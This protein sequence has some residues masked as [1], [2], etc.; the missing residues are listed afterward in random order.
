MVVA[1][2]GS[3]E[4]IG[5]DGTHVPYNNG[6]LNLTNVPSGRTG[7]YLS[8]TACGAPLGAISDTSWITSS[9]VNGT[10]TN[11]PDFCSTSVG[12]AT[13][14]A[15]GTGPF[16]YLWSPS[17]QTT[18]TATNLSGGTHTVVVTNAA[19]CTKTFLT[20]VA[21]NTARAAATTTRVSCP[22]GS[23]GTATASITP[24]NPNTVYDWYDLGNQT[25]ATVTGL[26]AGTYHCRVTSGSGCTD[27]V[28]VTITEVPAM[29]VTTTA[30][31]DVTCHAGSDGVATVAVA[32]GNSPYAYAWQGSSSTT[33]TATDLPVGSTVVTVTDSKGCTTQHTVTLG[34][35]DSLYV[36]Y[37]SPDVTICPGDSAIITANGS[38]GSSAY[39]YNWYS[40]GTLVGTGQT[41]TVSPAV[42]G[43][44]YKVVL[45][46]T[47][48]SPQ[49]SDSMIITFPTPLIPS[50]VPDAAQACQ[51]GAFF[52]RNT[53]NDSSEIATTYID[54]GNGSD[55]LVQGYGP[56]SSLYPEP[57]RYTVN[58]IVTSVH[59]CVYTNTLPNIVETL[60]NPTAYFTASANPATI[61]ETNI[62]MN[63]N[64]SMDVVDWKWSAPDAV[65]AQ[66]TM[67]SPVFYFPEGEIG[68]YPVTLVTTSSFGCVDTFTT[69]IHIVNDILFYA[70]NA[71][72]PDGNEYN[73]T[74]KLHIDGIDIHD[75]SLAVYNRWGQLIWET[76]DPS[77]DWDG[78]Y[79]GELVQ[80]GTYMWK[81]RVKSAYSD[82]AK[83]FNGFVS[84]LR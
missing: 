77:A 74:W 65:P 17:N 1:P 82:E 37:I 62:K 41:V 19:G 8:G 54:F 73:Q 69:I 81:A 79:N 27:T 18:A 14:T 25:T 67:E 39:I 49:A 47:C 22:G 45:T 59:G 10:I 63:N 50:L 33:A 57:N 60:K 29:T 7:Y 66:S 9:A 2:N 76:K 31:T 3:I 32:N 23:D 44:Y 38:G 71:F 58:M 55:T 84:L 12:T 78:T 48:G 24:A 64:S 75:F 56:V 30:Q 72:T 20:S 36:S 40:E 15:T 53:T 16:T 43:T 6:V 70:P 42:T 26:S 68:D 46:E 51:P 35:P 61:F 11:T 28:A 34:Q 83:T 4:W 5:T 80:E 13:V 21:N 52:F